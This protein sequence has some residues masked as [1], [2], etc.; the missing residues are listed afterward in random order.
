MELKDYQQQRIL[1]QSKHKKELAMLDRQYAL[2]NNPVKVGD[3]IINKHETTTIE[4]ENI[5]VSFG[6]GSNVPE[7]VY[8]G[9]NLTKAGTQSK[10]EPRNT[11]YQSQLKS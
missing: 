6:L 5:G 2:S 8:S 3:K 7:C 10:R 11:I 4:V 9:K 1:L